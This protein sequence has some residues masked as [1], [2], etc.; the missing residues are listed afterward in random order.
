VKKRESGIAYASSRIRPFPLA[1]SPTSYLCERNFPNQVH[2]RKWEGKT[3]QLPK[4]NNEHFNLQTSKCF[5]QEN[6]YYIATW[7]EC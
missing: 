6:V 7:L 1:A 2:L 4:I 5:K 3:T